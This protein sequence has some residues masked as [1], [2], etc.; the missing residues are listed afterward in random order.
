MNEPASPAEGSCFSTKTKCLPRLP[1]L[2]PSEVSSR[3]R[4]GFAGEWPRDPES[5][6]LEENIR[7]LF[8]SESVTGE[9][10]KGEN[11]CIEVIY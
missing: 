4:H 3:T 2:E 6:S 8:W 10:E 9:G 1:A 5:L 7:G 11:E